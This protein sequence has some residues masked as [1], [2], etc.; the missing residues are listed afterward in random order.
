M[1]DP[2][3]FAFGLHLHQPVGNFDHV[4]ASHLDDVYRPLLSAL[5]DGQVLPV[6]LH[7]SGPLLDW[8][9]THG[10]DWLDDLGRLVSDGKVEL[11]LSGYDEPILAMLPRADRL[12]QVAR[13]RQA[14]KTR[15]GVTATGLWL[16]ER[17]WEPDLA[18]DLADAGVEY[19]IVDDRH[20]LVAGFERHQLHRPWRT[21]AGGR[22]LSLFAIDERLRYLV[23]FRP[24]G[25]L[26]D[27]LRE[28]RAAGQPLAV[29]ADDGEKFGGWPG[30]REWVYD[31][32]WMADFQR[33]LRDMVD[34][35][36]LQLVTFAQALA[37]VP[38]DGPAYLPSASYRE[39]EGWALPPARARALA[40]LESELGAARLAGAE[41]A[42]VRGTHWRHF[43]AKYPESN[44]LHKKMLAL[45]ELCRERGDPPAARRAIGRAQCNDAYWHGVFGGL[46]LPFLRGALWKALASAEGI[47]RRGQPL[48]VERQD[49]DCDGREEIVVHDSGAS[50]V[51]SPHRGGVIEEWLHF[52]SGVNTAAVLTRRREAYHLDAMTPAVSHDTPETPPAADGA[53]SIHDLESGLVLDAL[54]PVDDRDRAL[55][56]DRVVAEACTVDRFI[57]GDMEDLAL[58]G[59]PADGVEL[60]QVE[61]QV[62]VTMTWPG[63]T[64]R[65]SV[66]PAGDI[67]VVLMWDPNGIPDGCLVTSEWSLFAPTSLE[68]DSVTEWRYGVETVAKSERGFDR[69][70]QGEAVVLVWP[71]EAG[72]GVVRVGG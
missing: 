71:A 45:S 50:V 9:D 63:R 13:M 19:A 49:I 60:E 67:E 18:A 6:T 37:T 43:L 25:E 62:R 33:T 47:L 27:Y 34:G 38:A 4:F 54:P 8:L 26:A 24:P 16:T 36:E 42:L 31:K 55:A 41:G 2:I 12:E 70:V 28:L 53:P 46:Y 44:R 7:V 68:T 40:A 39:M 1:T 66:G 5:R 58:W 72:R 69:T 61:G 20:F 10:A 32:G 48:Q 59:G 3:R 51:L 29:L 21:E 23:P 30:T 14:I 52:A 15:F 56:V 57:A 22:R 17:V 64:K 65:I 11:L 35:G